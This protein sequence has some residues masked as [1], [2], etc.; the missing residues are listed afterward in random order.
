MLTPLLFALKDI[1]EIVYRFQN[2]LIL[3]GT[4]GAFVDERLLL[5][6]FSLSDACFVMGHWVF[7]A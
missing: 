7:G 2:I 1:T 3:K 5:Y 6:E 4:K